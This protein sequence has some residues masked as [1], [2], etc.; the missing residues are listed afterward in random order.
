MKDWIESRKLTK[1]PVTVKALELGLKELQEYYPCDIF[2][3]IKCIH[4]TIVNGWK[5]FFPL[6]EKVNHSPPKFDD[7]WQKNRLAEL[8]AQRGIK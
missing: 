5:G 1:A 6:K 7:K 8:N 4:K 3:Q 2:T